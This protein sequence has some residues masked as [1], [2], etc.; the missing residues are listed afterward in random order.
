MAAVKQCG[1][2]TIP[3]LHPMQ[4][5]DQIC[6]EHISI[7]NRLIL[8]PSAHSL[9]DFSG[10]GDIALFIG[11]EGGF[12]LQEIYKSHPKWMGGLWFGA[13]RSARRHGYRFGTL[14]I[15]A[16]DVDIQ[17]EGKKSSVSAEEPEQPPSGVMASVMVCCTGSEYTEISSKPSL[18]CLARLLQEHRR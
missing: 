13:H 15:F 16:F 18:G 11:P 7:P 10:C 6:L 17:V 14:F 9:S 3:K 4:S 8:V 2:T 1:R 12:L 5:F